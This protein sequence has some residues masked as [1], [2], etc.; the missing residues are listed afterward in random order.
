MN[1]Q[2]KIKAAKA[3]QKQQKID[4][5]LVSE[6]FPTVQEIAV[7]MKYNQTGVLEPLSR[8]V[9][10]APGS[11]AIFK[12]SCLCSECIEGRFDFTQIITTMVGN[13]KTISRGKIN[14]DSCTAPECLDVDYSITIKYA[15]TK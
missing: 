14:C 1:R 2:M 12:A 9:N 7:S 5:G 10:F 15:Q 3:E 8:T 11:S 6:L 4:A 13:H